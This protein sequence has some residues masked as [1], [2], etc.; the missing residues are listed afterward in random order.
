M[1]RRKTHWPSSRINARGQKTAECGNYV[2]PSSLVTAPERVTC[3]RCKRALEIDATPPGTKKC[4]A[5]EEVKAYRYFYASNSH[6]DGCQSRCAEC[7]R[8]RALAAYYAR[9]G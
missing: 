5:C 2:D 9:K 7:Q 8:H 1:T 4:I 3:K 6:R